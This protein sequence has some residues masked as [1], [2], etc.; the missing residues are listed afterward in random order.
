MAGTNERNKAKKAEVQDVASVAPAEEAAQDSGRESTGEVE[1]KAP[2]TLS[3]LLALELQEKL[4]AERL[5][6]ELDKRL[7]EEGNES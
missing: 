6:R 3:E 5:A 4:E 1:K 7:K 2:K